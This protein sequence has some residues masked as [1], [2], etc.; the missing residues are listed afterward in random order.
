MPYNGGAAFEI[1]ATCNAT[2][3]T[4]MT[5][6]NNKKHKHI[7]HHNEANTNNKESRKLGTQRDRGTYCKTTPQSVDTY[8]CTRTHKRTNKRLRVMLPA[9]PPLY[10]TTITA[11]TTSTTTLKK[12]SVRCAAATFFATIARGAYCGSLPT[13]KTRRKRVGDFFFTKK[14]TSKF[15][16]VSFFMK[17]RKEKH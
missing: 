2:S 8:C 4:T 6:S 1:G 10:H 11:A 12:T 3:N 17:V 13:E 7:V 5:R 16:V 14:E 9:L 15:Q